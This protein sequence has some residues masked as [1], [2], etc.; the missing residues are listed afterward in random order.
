MAPTTIRKLQALGLAAA[1]VLDSALPPRRHPAYPSAAGGGFGRD[2]EG[3]VRFSAARTVVA[4]LRVGSAAASVV[5]VAVAAGAAIPRVRAA[6]ADRTPPASPAMW[7]ALQI[8]LGTVWAEEAA[9]RAALTTLAADG[10]GPRIGR[11][12]QAIA[13][14]LSHISDARAAGQ[15]VAATFVVTGAAGWVFGALAERS[16]SLAAPML[17][18]LA[19]NEAGAVAAL[20]VQAG[21]RRP[22]LNRFDDARATS[23]RTLQSR[24]FGAANVAVAAARVVRSSVDLV[25]LPKPVTRDSRSGPDVAESSRLV[26][27][28]PGGPSLDVACCR[29]VAGGQAGAPAR[30]VEWERCDRHQPHR[31]FRCG[32]GGGIPDDRAAGRPDVDRDPRQRR[33]LEG[34]TGAPTTLRAVSCCS[35]RRSRSTTAQR[36]LGE[37]LCPGFVHRCSTA[38]WASKAW[39]PR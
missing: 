32:D 27:E 3:A 15:P 26:P 24:R 6:M 39:R 38:S 13:F 34:T 14:G 7:L 37:R 2:H 28:P 36:H 22:K 20:R 29:E 31:T 30:S 12:V 10:F 21:S 35:R 19:I 33:G 17:T 1:L 11:L 5:T 16:G 9:Y 25:A 8:P 18:H 4:G 23:R